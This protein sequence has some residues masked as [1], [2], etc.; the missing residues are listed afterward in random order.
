MSAAKNSKAKLTT[1]AM[2]QIAVCTA[3]M[4]AAAQISIPLPIP[5]PFTLQVLMVILIAL[6]L[7]PL[8]ALI[9]QVLYTLLGIAG[10]P[11]FSGGKSGIGTVLSPTG[12]FIIGFIIAAFLVSLLKGSSEKKTAIVRYI[13]VSILVGIPCIY[14]P[15]IAMYMVYVDTDLL[16]AI[17]TLTS[18]FIVVD[19]AKCVIASALAVPLNKA[20]KRITA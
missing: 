14:I 3:M 2:A 7:K 19:I 5:V 20:L 12:G 15:G 6:I 8:Y 1:L 9:S 16:S 11:V 10:L 18:L 17:A 4:C 13:I